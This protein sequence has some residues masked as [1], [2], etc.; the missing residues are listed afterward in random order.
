MSVLGKKLKGIQRKCMRIFSQ[1]L[2]YSSYNHY[3]HT[4]FRAKDTYKF[5][6]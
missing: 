2:A 3:T 4:Y 5:K 6:V 1:D